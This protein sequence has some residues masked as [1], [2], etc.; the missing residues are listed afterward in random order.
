[1]EPLTVF[2]T[3]VI[4]IG[5]FHLLAKTVEAINKHKYRSVN[6]AGKKRIDWYC[7]FSLSSLIGNRHNETD[8][9][10]SDQPNLHQDTTIE[11]YKRRREA[12]RPRLNIS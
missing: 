10:A 3:S 4:S 5:I 12:Q 11:E 9:E 6:Q 1:M 2:A 7:F 8:H